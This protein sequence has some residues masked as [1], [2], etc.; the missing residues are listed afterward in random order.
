MS[1]RE[2]CE[3]DIEDFADLARQLGYEVNKKHLM[4]RIM[5]KNENE[6][7]FV[8]Y[9]CEKIVGW[10]DCRISS[11]YLVEKHCEIVGLI[12]DEKH[13]GK[14]IGKSLVK[15]GEDWAKKNSI[16]KVTVRSNVKRERA[17]KFYIENGYEV[18]K[19]SMVFEKEI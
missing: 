11:T 7:V 6:I 18:K 12:V 16:D 10:I 13:R 19:Q 15:S 1:I 2:L 3:T 9:E 5:N 14:K 8:Y 4:D 17:H